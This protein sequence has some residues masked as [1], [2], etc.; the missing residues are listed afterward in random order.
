MPGKKRSDTVNVKR[1]G[2]MLAALLAAMAVGVALCWAVMP[3]PRGAV[4]AEQ[5][6]SSAIFPEGMAPLRPWRFIVLHHT[7][8]E[9]GDVQSLDLARRRGVAPA[10]EPACHFLIGNGRG[11]ADGALVC[12]DRWLR[13]EP[14]FELPA[15]SAEPALRVAAADYA[16]IRR[17]GITVTLVGDFARHG[18][19]AKQMDTLADLV[20]TLS[21]R[22]AIPLTD[23]L[24]HSDVQAVSC[25]GPQLPAGD[26]FRRVGE[27]CRGKARPQ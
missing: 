1:V 9:Q 15:D 19:T 8:T 27:R 7:A 24:L 6:T 3:P 25:P 10:G 5:R 23:V 12:T 2:T 16:T 20:Y 14:A 26:L 18:P 4:A 17:Q 11:L 13:Q 22:F 21:D